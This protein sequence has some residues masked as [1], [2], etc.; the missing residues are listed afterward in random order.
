M[1]AEPMETC[2]GCGLVLRQVEG[3]GH[4][5]IGASVSC[6]A[7]YGEVLAREFGELHYPECH[8]LTV[9][10]YAVQHPGVPGP[11]SRRSVGGHLVTLCLQLEHGV[12]ADAAT[13]MLG[14]F[15]DYRSE[16]PWLDPPGHRGDLTVR[17]VVATSGLEA[18]TDLVQRWARGVWQAWQPH[19]AT[20]HR[21]VREADLL[22]G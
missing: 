1:S 15:L 17:D 7:L 19:H 22:G 14:T 21:W 6:W 16:L 8:R 18:H 10:A 5:Y 4:A 2:A 11:Q 12:S 20:V 9:D 13:R 3:P